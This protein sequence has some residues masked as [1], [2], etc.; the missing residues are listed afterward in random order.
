MMDLVSLG[1]RLF[2]GIGE[3]SCYRQRNEWTPLRLRSE[4]MGLRHLLPSKPQSRSLFVDYP[5]LIHK[6]LP[7]SALLLT[8]C[9]VSKYQNFSLWFL[10]PYWNKPPA[11]LKVSQS[12]SNQL[13][14][15]FLVK[16]CFPFGDSGLLV[17]GISIYILGRGNILNPRLLCSSGLRGSF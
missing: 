11:A 6:L 16:Q 13:G 12:E 7:P 14:C 8:I 10:T 4:Q 9:Q 5:M 1:V 3:K 2:E 15:F 17:Q